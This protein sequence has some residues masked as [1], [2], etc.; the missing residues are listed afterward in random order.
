MSLLKLILHLHLPPLKR[1]EYYRMII[2]PLIS[3]LDAFPK[4][5]VWINILFADNYFSEDSMLIM[6]DVCTRNIYLMDK[7][8]KRDYTNKNFIFCMPVY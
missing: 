4:K 6:H 7:Y 5:C 1:T 2:F 3:F 8:V